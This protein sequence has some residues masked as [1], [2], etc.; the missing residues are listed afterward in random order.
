MN[1]NDVLMQ[2]V[3]KNDQISEQI[4]YRNEAEGFKHARETRETEEPEKIHEE[5]S[6]AVKEI[7]AAERLKQVEADCVAMDE[8]RHADALKKIEKEAKDR[9]SELERLRTAA[10]VLETENRLKKA[11]DEEIAE[12]R[13]KTVKKNSVLERLQQVEADRVAMDAS[14]HVDEL[15]KI[16]KEAKERRSELERLRTA[17]SALELANRL[18]KAEEEEMAELRRKIAAD[19]DSRQSATQVQSSKKKSSRRQDEVGEGEWRGGF[20]VEGATSEEEEVERRPVRRGFKVKKAPSKSPRRRPAVSEDSAGD[21]EEDFP[22]RNPKIRLAGRRPSSTSLRVEAEDDSMYEDE[23]DLPPRPRKSARANR[24]PQGSSGS[25]PDLSGLLTQFRGTPMGLGSSHGS[26]SNS[27][28][29]TY[30]SHSSP[31][32]VPYGYAPGTVVNSGVGNITNTTFS[33]VGNNNSVKHVYR[34]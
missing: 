28:F 10:S 30:G 34:K 32:M 7:S 29:P 31:A 5:E 22:L 18:R 21:D 2:L 17:A 23:D 25:T 33:N 27:Y 1:I 26:G 20:T 3:R 4:L 14:W 16:E 24:E 6:K 9:L 19:N 13:R 15:K 12:L 8:R 11:Q